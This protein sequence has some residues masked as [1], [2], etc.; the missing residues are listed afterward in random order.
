MREMQRYENRL[1]LRAPGNKARGRCG[2]NLII[3]CRLHWIITCECF[4]HHT[5]LRKLR[6]WLTDAD[7][8]R[9]LWEV[10][11][12]TCVSNSKVLNG[13]GTFLCSR[14]QKA[15]RKLTA[16]R[17]Q[18]EPR[19]TGTWWWEFVP[20]SE[21][22]AHNPPATKKLFIWKGC[23]TIQLKCSHTISSTHFLLFWNKVWSTMW[24]T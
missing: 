3:S 24:H 17:L 11:P 20:L 4:Q 1:Q 15:E 12:S 10:L 23:N 19:W 22:A 2:Q 14:M 18:P 5:W 7:Q 21:P 8:T 13:G 16:C 9:L 6:C